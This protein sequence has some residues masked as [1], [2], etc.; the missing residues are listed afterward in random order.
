MHHVA[1]DGQVAKGDELDSGAR[2]V[3]RI[4]ATQIVVV[5]GVALDQR[6]GVAEAIN[7]LIATASNLVAQDLRLGV[8]VGRAAQ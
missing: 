7:A 2:P 5:D 6:V 4:K 1:V 8:R 3:H